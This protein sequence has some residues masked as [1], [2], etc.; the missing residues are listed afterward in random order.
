M[1]FGKEREEKDEEGGF[2]ADVMRRAIE[3]SLQGLLGEASE[4]VGKEPSARETA[5][6]DTARSAEAARSDSK[7]ADPE[8]RRNQF[9]AQILPM[10][11]RE[12]VQSTLQAVDATKR[13]AVSMIGREVQQFLSGLNVSDE[14]TKILTSVSFEIK[15]EVRFIPN[16]DGG[17]RPVVTA[18]GRPKSVAATKRGKPAAR[19][20][21]GR[22][23]PAKTVAPDSAE[24]GKASTRSR[25]K[26]SSSG[27][28]ADAARSTVQAISDGTRDT[29]RRVVDRIAERTEQLT[30]VPE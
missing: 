8:D 20:T 29:V 27:Q 17:L 9:I 13:E 12:L 3:R 15:T 24:S 2:L 6:A 5:R 21:P 22:K 10:L 16:E 30:G 26:R 19:K 14:L 23:K 28:V 11:P 4:S 7:A 1:V 25:S 18:S